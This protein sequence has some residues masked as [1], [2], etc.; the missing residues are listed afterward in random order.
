MSGELGGSRDDP[1][2]S[3]QPERPEAPG[4]PGRPGSR[5]G[6]G[7]PSQRRA[8]PSRAPA[9]APRRASGARCRSGAPPRR[10]AFERTR[11]VGCA[12]V[13]DRA[14]GALTGERPAAARRLRSLGAW[15]GGGV[16]RRRFVQHEGELGMRDSRGGIC[17]VGYRAEDWR[18]ARRARQAERTRP[19][20][21]EA[22]MSAAGCSSGAPCVEA[23]PDRKGAGD[24]E[25]IC[26]GMELVRVSGGRTDKI[27]SR[28]A[29]PSMM[30]ET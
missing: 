4:P 29:V 27:R 28:V 3:R 22:S 24:D 1:H 5:D 14:R 13:T 21:I 25:S 23:A 30:F 11:A 9:H 6:R 7:S 18:R 15:S 20:S 16:P 10:W 8:S 12:L 17:A 2:W 26:S 19:G